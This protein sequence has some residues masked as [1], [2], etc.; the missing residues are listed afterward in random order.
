MQHNKWS[1]RR[2]GEVFFLAERPQA[3]VHFFFLLFSAAEDEPDPLPQHFVLVLRGE[4][5][6]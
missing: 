6:G 5:R 4:A 2:I 3:Q 1:R